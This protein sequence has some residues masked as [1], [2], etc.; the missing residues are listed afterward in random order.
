MAFDVLLSI[1][2]IG[3]D[4]ASL[5]LRLL[6]GIIF[7]VH[8]YPKIK[9]FKGTAGFLGSLGFKPGIF[10]AFILAFTEFGGA[11]ALL[12]GWNIRIFCILLLGS[13]IV[14]TGLKAF[15]WHTG[16]KADKST[17][18]EFDLL[19]IAALIALFL[20]GPGSLRLF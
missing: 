12:C 1:N 11:L 14:A 10:W 7:L 19:I 6:L 16:F 9:N 4:W 2:P 15:V 20:I 3:L 13:M 17:G 18:Y 8:G 5:S